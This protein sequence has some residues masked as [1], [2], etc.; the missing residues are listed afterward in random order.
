M[1]SG[2]SRD[3]VRSDGGKIENTNH[4]GNL[5]DDRNYISF[6]VKDDLGSC[7]GPSF[8]NGLTEIRPQILPACSLF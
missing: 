7:H 4:Q 3:V 1:S 6:S 2:D 8:F 5:Q